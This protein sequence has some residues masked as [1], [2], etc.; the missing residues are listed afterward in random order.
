MAWPLSCVPCSFCARSVSGSILN[1][2][3]I[4]KFMLLKQ[5]HQSTDITPVLYNLKISEEDMSLKT[6][7]S[8]REQATELRSLFRSL[9]RQTKKMES[10]EAALNRD[11]R[12]FTETVN[13]KVYVIH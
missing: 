2:S 4:F 12:D 1:S 13:K 6:P 5:V 8:F 3:E 7:K 10:K 11:A 9:T